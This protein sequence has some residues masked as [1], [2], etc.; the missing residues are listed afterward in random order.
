MS[1]YNHRAMVPANTT[2]MADMLDAIKLEFDQLNQ[3]VILN[4]N[5]RDEYEHKGF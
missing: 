5:L 1:V 4:K 3:E 2:R